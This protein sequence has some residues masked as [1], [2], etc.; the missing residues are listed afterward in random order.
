MSESQPQPDITMM[1][2]QDAQQEIGNL[3]AE[4]F[5]TRQQSE[6]RRQVIERAE[7]D[8][9]H[10][11]DGVRDL[12]AKLTEAQQRCQQ[13]SGVEQQVQLLNDRVAALQQESLASTTTAREFERLLQAE[14]KSRQSAEQAK[15]RLESEKSRLQKSRDE[16]ATQVRRSPSRH[17]HL[18]DLAPCCLACMLAPL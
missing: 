8:N 6:E 17:P 7:A 16:L 12:R 18:H 1:L 15:S 10:L 5:R 3:R 9:A 14:A 11:Q 4:L 13:L 2:L